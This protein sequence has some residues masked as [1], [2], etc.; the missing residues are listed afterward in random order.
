MSKKIVIRTKGKGPMKHSRATPTAA[1]VEK[2]SLSGFRDIEWPDCDAVKLVYNDFRAVVAAGNQAT[3]VYRLNSVFDPDFTGVGGQPAGFDQLKALYGRYRVMACKVR[4]S[5]ASM[6]SG[7][8]VF[9][10]AA[11]VDNNALASIAEDVASL[12]HAVSQVASFG[13]KV[14]VVEKVYHIGEL[15]GYSDEAVLGN[16][17]MDA[18]VTGNPGFQ[19][20]LLIAV[21][22]TGVTD[23][24]ELETELTYYTRMEVA[25][26]VEDSMSRRK[27]FAARGKIGIPSTKKVPIPAVPRTQVLTDLA[28]SLV[29]SVNHDGKPIDIVKLL[30]LL[31]PLQCAEP[32]VSV[33][34]DGETRDQLLARVSALLQQS[35]AAA[36]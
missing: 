7:G 24:I 22:T 10:A 31:S 19:Q 26:A 16:T 13:S 9:L 18:L 32:P 34:S 15:L 30:E 23:Q 1:G 2:M 6:T 11:P 8:S 14:A 25:T 29:G 33:T 27:S 17:N 3:Y 21:E 4:I 12:R 5:C 28:K 36:K 35:R 20:Y